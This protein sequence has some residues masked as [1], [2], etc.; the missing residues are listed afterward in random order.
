MHVFVADAGER[1]GGK[2]YSSSGARCRGKG[3]GGR[4]RGWYRNYN[5]EEE[6]KQHKATSGNARGGEAHNTKGDSAKC[7]RCGET[8]HKS[9]CCPD[10]VCGVYGGKGNST[11]ICANV[12]SVIAYEDTKDCTDYSDATI[13]GEEKAAFICDTPGEYNNE[14]NDEMGCSTLGKW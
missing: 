10:H 14:S 12:V 4:G 3:R 1:P 13:S 8:G 11:K 7:K 9:V 2:R 5:D 6:E